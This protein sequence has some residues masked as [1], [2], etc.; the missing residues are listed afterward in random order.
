[1]TDEGSTKAEAKAPG[2]G[3][4]D[5]MANDRRERDELRQQRE[6]IDRE[7]LTLLRQR[8]RLSRQVASRATEPLKATL[9]STERDTLEALAREGGDDLPAPAVLGVFRQ[10]HAVCRSLEAPVRTAYVGAEGCGAYVVAF[11]RFGPLAEMSACELVS[12]ALEHVDRGRADFAVLP[13]ET[14]AEGL[15]HASLM[16]LGATELKIVALHD[17]KTPLALLS[18]GGN[19]GAIERVFATAIDRASAQHNL[20]TLLPRVSVVDVKTS[21]AACSM[22]LEDPSASALALEALGHRTG[23]AVAARSVADVGEGRQR[24]CIVAARPASRTGRDAT[25]ITFAVSD[26]PGQLFE[27]LKPFAERGV[28][29]RTIQSRSPAREEQDTVFYIEVSG[30]VT[31]RAMVTALEGVKNQTRSFKVLGSYPVP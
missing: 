17:V 20:A 5:V 18:Q 7:I 8:A 24:F 27:V 9:P 2:R 25:T 6:Q 29:V 26:R 4:T 30:H 22:A 28:N 1:L 13:Y 14:S 12:A 11:E 15:D 31:D 3:Y 10:I 21:V 16:A 19:L 23:L